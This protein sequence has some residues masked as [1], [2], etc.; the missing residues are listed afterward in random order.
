LPAHPVVGAEL[1]KALAS[2]GQN[3]CAGAARNRGARTE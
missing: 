2:T 3:H 1:F